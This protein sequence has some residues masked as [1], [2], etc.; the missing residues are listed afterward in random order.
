M[1]L[2]LCPKSFEPVQPGPHIDATKLYIVIEEIAG[3]EDL[4]WEYSLE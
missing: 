1:N 3:M 2:S 4:I